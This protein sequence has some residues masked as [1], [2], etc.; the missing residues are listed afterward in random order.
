MDSVIAA[1]HVSEPG[2]VVLGI[3]ATDEESALARS[4]SRRTWRKRPRNAPPDGRPACRQA[5]SARAVP[6]ARRRCPR[7]YGHPR[8]RRPRSRVG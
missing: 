7:P 1:R 4:A 5:V 8:E 2:L 6:R 3:T